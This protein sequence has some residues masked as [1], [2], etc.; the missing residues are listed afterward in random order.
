[1]KTTSLTESPAPVVAA[2]V[3]RTAIGGMPMGHART[4]FADVCESPV[5][6]RGWAATQALRAGWID[7]LGI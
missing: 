5:L 6:T 7:D 4:R 1:V 3:W 2:Y